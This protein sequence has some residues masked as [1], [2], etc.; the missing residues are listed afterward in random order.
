MDFHILYKGIVIESFTSP[1]IASAKKYV[2]ARYMNRGAGCTL[3]WYIG[4][5]ERS[6]EL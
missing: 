2:Q 5:E 6:I 3:I 1:R 4:G